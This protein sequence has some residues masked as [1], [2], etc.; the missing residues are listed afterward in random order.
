MN[1]FCFDVDKELLI[2][3]ERLKERLGFEEGTGI[4]VTAVKG[5]KNGVT[6]SDGKAVIYYIKKPIFFRYLSIL[7]K[8]A[9]TK[10]E[11]EIFE[12]THFEELSI[13]IDTSRNGVP[14]VR[15]VLDIIDRIVMLGYTMAMLYTEDTVEI[16]ERPYFGYMRG[17]YTEDELRRIDDYAFD[18]GIEVIPCL[19]CYGHMEKYLIWPEAAA[20]KD[21]GSVLLAREEKTFEF[22]DDLLRTTSSIFRSKR[23]HI[24]MDEA[25]DMGRG[26]FL[27]KHG[28]VPP[29]EIFNEFMERLVQITNKYG[30]IP[31]MW[32]DMYFR[33][34]SANQRGYYEKDIEITPE[35]AAKIPEEV[36]LV[37]WHYG[38][39]YHCDEY[40]LE[41]H[42]ALGRKVI[43]AGGLWGWCGHF[44]EHQISMDAIKYSL[45]ACRHQGVREAM[46]TVW[47]NDN[48]ECDFYTNMFGISYFAELCYDENATEQKLRERFEM[49]TGG[50]YDAF[51]NMTY[52]NNK[53]ESVDE[54]LGHHAR[55]IGKPMFWQDIMEGLFDAYL[56]EMP[57]SDHYAKYAETFKETKGGE[58][59]YLYDFAYKVFDYLSVKTYIA[60]NL[61]PAY[62]AG[63]KEKLSEIANVLLPLLK[64]K[65]ESV[66]RAHKDIWLDHFKTLGLS[67]LEVRYAGVMARCETARELIGRYLSGK[68][69]VI[70]AL[71]Q[72]RLK[73]PMSGFIQYA[74]I[75]SPNIKI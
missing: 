32:S 41:K 67:N 16:K 19:E 29:F 54:K 55:F 38:E 52:Y 23:V 69:E 8:E 28:Y 58:F 70:E 72:D 43:Y 65:T 11:F 31:M 2:G 30:L 56:F 5:D 20:I 68:D 12:D 66:Y 59:T 17:R 64:K 60:E 9:E 46:I 25:W 14:N 21:T 71:E 13:M 22:L 50:D 49:L 57:M 26:A 3:I 10:N 53:L 62:K 74:A 6:L 35:V 34:C 36:E 4:T 27:T 45:S 7:V 42:N 75:S 73:K 24:G 15:T 39:K 51:Y 48:A 33:V 63:D 37:F 47:T 18:Y 61:Y 40:M 44:P 1:K